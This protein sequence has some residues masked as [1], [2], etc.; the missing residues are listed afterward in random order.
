MQS[1]KRIYYHKY[2]RDFPSDDNAYI[3]DYLMNREVTSKTFI[4]TIL[5]LVSKI[6]CCCLEFNCSKFIILASATVLI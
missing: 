5:D 6:I 4:V 3:V 1:N 2:Y